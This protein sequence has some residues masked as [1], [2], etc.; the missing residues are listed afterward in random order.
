MTPEKVSEPTESPKVTLKKKQAEP[1]A[2]PEPKQQP[3]AE[4]RPVEKKSGAGKIV[5]GVAAAAIVIAGAFLLLNRDADGDKAT[6]SDAAGNALAQNE[7]AVAEESQEVNGDKVLPDPKNDSGAAA[8]TEAKLQES[9]SASEEKA[10]PSTAGAA[11][12]SAQPEAKPAEEPNPAQQTAPSESRN[13]D[14]SAIEA[15]ALQ[16]IR[17][18]FGNG[19]ER[20]DRLGANYAEIQ[21]KV[22]DMYRK[23]LVR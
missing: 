4:A 6:Q 14:E 20:K 22:N 8:A 21:G 12:Q 5:A 13:L 18:D 16:V 3:R 2:A 1:A 7:R 17:G 19:Q 15:K 11:E 9:A 10:S 23:G